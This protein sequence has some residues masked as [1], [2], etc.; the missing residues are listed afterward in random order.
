MKLIKAQKKLAQRIDVLEKYREM[1][2]SGIKK[3][4]R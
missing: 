2:D 4:K 3:E 1:M